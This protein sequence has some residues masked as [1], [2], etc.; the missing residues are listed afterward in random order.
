[1]NEESRCVAFTATEEMNA[2]KIDQRGGIAGFRFRCPAAVF[3]DDD[4]NGPAHN[5][6]R[7]F[8]SKE[9]RG[10]CD[11]LMFQYSVDLDLVTQRCGSTCQRSADQQ[12]RVAGSLSH[13]GLAYQTKWLNS[14]FRFEVPSA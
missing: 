4:R 11:P 13:L 14:M 7:W 5:S 12:F 8:L 10:I 2:Q 6:D 1:M 9:L 3:R